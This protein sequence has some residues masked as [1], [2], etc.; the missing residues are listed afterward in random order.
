ML[1]NRPMDSK[2]V[3]S[4]RPG[5]AQTSKSAVSQVSKPA[6]RNIGWPANPGKLG[7][8]RIMR[9]ILHQSNGR[10]LQS[11]LDPT[12]IQSQSSLNPTSIQS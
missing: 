7:Q 3:Q 10:L 11:E 2:K 4:E 12:L 5:V 8:N 1:Q 9:K 6:L